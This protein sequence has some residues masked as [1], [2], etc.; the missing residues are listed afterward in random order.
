MTDLHHLKIPTAPSEALAAVLA[1][2]E[3]ADQ[4]ERKAVRKALEDGWTWAQIAEALGVS[5]QAAHK[6]H[7]ASLARG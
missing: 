2:R 7:A 4:I 6:K 3:L 1:L 5:R